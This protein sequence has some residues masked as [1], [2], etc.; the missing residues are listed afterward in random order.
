MRKR[1]PSPPAC[2]FLLACVLCR[3][4][5][6][7]Q[8]EFVSAANAACTDFQLCIENFRAILLARMN[9]AKVPVAQAIVQLAS[10]RND[11]IVADCV[12]CPNGL[13]ERLNSWEDTRAVVI[14]DEHLLRWD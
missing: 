6:G 5:P 8:A 3:P 4:A 12:F 14:Q 7:Q 2:P 1:S 11:Q 13:L 9:D 10:K